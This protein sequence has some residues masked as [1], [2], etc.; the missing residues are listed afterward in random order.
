M[1]LRPLRHPT[2]GTAAVRESADINV[3]L[4]EFLDAPVYAKFIGYRLSRLG[5]NLVILTGDAESRYLGTALKEAGVRAKFIPWNFG[6]PVNI[7]LPDPESRL[8]VFKVPSLP[9]HWSELQALRLRFGGR[10]LGINEL[11]LPLSV[12]L[13]ARERLPYS[14]K[15]LNELLIYYI[16]RSTF[17]A[18]LRT[19]TDV[20][21]LEG[22]SV[23]E[24]GPLDASQTAFL[25]H[26]G[27]SRVVCVEARPENAMKVLAA[28]QAMGWNN[29]EVRMDDFH[30]ADAN[31][32]GRFDLAFAHGV[33]YH[34]IA[35]F[36]FL[37][38]L[39]SLSDN[40]FLGG[41]C[42]TDENPAIEY[43]HLTHNGQSYRVKR[44]EEA[45]RGDFYA[46]INS[47]AYF[48][49]GE[50]L[51]KFFQTN[52]YATRVLQDIPTDAT[53]AAGRYI[54]FFASREPT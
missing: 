39:I 35:P 2:A 37:E 19:L 17:G 20:F 29:V 50:D 4:N 7:E 44:Y 45:G 26:S 12:L 53:Q 16:G 27:A 33:Y 25:V 34:T 23:V 9:E 51:L 11:L 24:F 41:Y 8:L 38:N 40:V 46:G 21:P 48:L 5:G 1:S 6:Q 36:V 10:V 28:R 3:I 49:E 31:S 15:N 42:T 22:K 52:G 18:P 43:Q 30:N 32:M 54:R 14:V 47:Y 13:H